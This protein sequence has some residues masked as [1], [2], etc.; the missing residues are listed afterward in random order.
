VDSAGSAYCLVSHT[1]G[2]DNRPAGSIRGGEFLDQLNDY[3]LSK[4]GS[5]PWFV[6]LPLALKLCAAPRTDGCYGYYTIREEAG[7][8]I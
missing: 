5:I 7:V 3:Q 1:C 6:C 2:Q 4:R 8:L